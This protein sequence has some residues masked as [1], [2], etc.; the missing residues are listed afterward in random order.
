MNKK[1][2]LRFLLKFCSHLSNPLG[3]ANAPHPFLDWDFGSDFLPNSIVY[4]IQS[5]STQIIPPVLL[6]SIIQMVEANYLHKAFM[7]KLSFFS[8]T[9]PF[10][11]D[12]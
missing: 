9:N 4:S 5:S 11:L 12:R 10:P 8:C 7:S 2:T 6:F 1:I 3:G